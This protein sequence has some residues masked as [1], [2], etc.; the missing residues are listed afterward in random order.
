MA[1]NGPIQ[2]LINIALLRA[3]P[4]DL[5]FSTRLM[6]GA[7]VLTAA[8]NYP[9]VAR[10]TPQAEPLVQILLLIGYNLVFVTAALRLRDRSQRFV[11]TA[12]ALFGT[13][14]IISL[15]ALPVLFTI[16]SPTEANALAA[17]SFLVLIG[18]NI[19][20]VNH[21]LRAA[22]D[23]RTGLTLGITLVYIFGASMF[24][25]AVSGV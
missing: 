1:G 23:L 9:V 10:Y 14:V 18:W 16:G 24:V 5:P 22:L 17:L 15:A 4:Q 21:I 6:G 8:I 3:G 20:V 2:T 25:R 12:T 7:L 13:D 19:A 11:Q